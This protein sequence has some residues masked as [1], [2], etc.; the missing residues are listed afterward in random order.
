MLLLTITFSIN[1]I[2]GSEEDPEIVDEKNENVLKYLDIISAWF[3]E[4]EDQPDYLFI[5]LKLKEINPYHLKQHLSVNWEYNGEFCAAGLIIGY[6]KPWFY[7][8]AGYG[9]GFWFQEFYDE[10]NGDFDSETGIIT[11]EIP[12]EIIKNPQQGD[13]L[14]KTKAST[15][16][17]YGF[18]GRLGFSR[19]M[20]SSLVSITMGYTPW[21]GAPYE[22][23]RNYIIQY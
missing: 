20:I 3:F 14:T 13:T 8:S 15:F 5:S 19:F 21:D 16:Q 17:R 18:I 1:V 10:I 7:Y 23:G 2:A 9:H 11:L 12:K 6:G 4:K 22:Y